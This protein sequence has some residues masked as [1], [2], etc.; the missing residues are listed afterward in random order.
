M[1]QCNLGV[2]VVGAHDLMPKDRHGSA[3]VCV[4][5]QFDGQK[6]RT[7]VKEKDLNPVWNEHFYFA[8]SDL[9]DLP[10]MHL[11]ACIYNVNKELHT[12]SFLGKVRII[13]TSFV[14]RSEAVM[15]HYPL[16]KRGWFSR[17]KGELGMKV[18]LT[19]DP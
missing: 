16:E 14:P 19:D 5:L 9:S 8:I 7:S 6:F 17:V 4:E 18:F 10:N 15:M 11:E 2:E 1:A 12:R 13:G 3:C